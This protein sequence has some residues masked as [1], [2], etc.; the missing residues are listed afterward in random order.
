MPYSQWLKAS[1]WRFLWYIEVYNLVGMME[2]TVVNDSNQRLATI[3]LFFDCLENIVLFL[4][5]EVKYLDE[6][7]KSILEVI[8][9]QGRVS[10][11]TFI[12]SLI[13][14]YFWI[15]IVW[16]KKMWILFCS[17]ES[18]WLT[19]QIW[20]GMMMRLDPLPRV[21]SFFVGLLILLY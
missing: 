17:L 10:N 12:A 11:N 7:K 15:K 8:D 5:K 9:F 13:L 21:V 19:L 4:Y 20:W 6:N 3:V 1:S 18:S 14:F 2:I 16:L